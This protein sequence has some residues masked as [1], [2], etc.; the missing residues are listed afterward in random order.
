MLFAASSMNNVRAI[1]SNYQN[2][3]RQEAI[4]EIVC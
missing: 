3:D 1:S 2:V 4:I